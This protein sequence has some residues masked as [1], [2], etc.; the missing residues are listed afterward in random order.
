MTPL[1]LVLEAAAFAAMAHAPQRRKTG[2]EPYVNHVVRVA[3]EASR[4]GLAPEA[5][6]AALLHDVVEDTRFGLDDVRARFPPRVVELVHL[7]TQWWADDAPA[8]VKASEKP[9]YYAAILKDAD[10]I[11]LK[12]LDRADNLE[13]MAGVA[14]RARRWAERYLRR[15]EEEMAPLVEAVALP[16]VRA[17]YEAA[18]AALRAALSR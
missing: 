11:A 16:G 2:H 5:V 14:D 10:A 13:D 8:A 15:S 9:K 1:E 3:R 18:L 6:A 7:M 4:Q 17:R 12:L